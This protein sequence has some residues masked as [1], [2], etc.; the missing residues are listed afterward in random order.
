MFFGDD[1]A[2]FN[3]DDKQVRNLAGKTVRIIAEG[4]MDNPAITVVDFGEGQHPR[5]FP[6]TF[7][8][9]GH[10]NRT[11]INFAQ[12][13]YNQGG[14]AALKF[15]GNGYQL[16][17]SR[18]A[19]DISNK[20]SD[21]GFTLVRERYEPGSRAEQYEY[22]LARNGEEYA[23]PSIPFEPL[24]ILPG[25]DKLDSGTFI[26]LYNYT[27]KNPNLFITG[28]RERELARSVSE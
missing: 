4:Q 7:L 3:I 8:S 18:R 2:D 9:I 15:C 10:S 17:I 24:P 26:R 22:C 19:P 28:Q 14:S 23:I 5:D 20:D 25:K 12:G 6:D 21:W 11:K 1:V 16:V 13:V 27:L